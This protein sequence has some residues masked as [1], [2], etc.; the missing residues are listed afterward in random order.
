MIGERT[1]G[2]PFDS[3]ELVHAL[4]RDGALRWG[5]HGWIWDTE[6]IR[7]S[8][9]VGDVVDLITARLRRLS[10]PT[11]S[12]LSVMA[13]LGGH[14]RLRVLA[15]ASALSSSELL[16]LLEPD[17]RRLFDVLA[18]YRVMKRY[19]R[20]TLRLWKRCWQRLG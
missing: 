14:G 8:V 18:M 2:N 17:G 11:Q 7:R 4:H 9:G 1:D 6:S 3:I 12:I 5:E 10:E 19:S 15:I 20:L 16:D 13:C